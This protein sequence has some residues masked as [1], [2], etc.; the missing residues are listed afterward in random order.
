[1]ITNLQKKDAMKIIA[2][3]LIISVAIT[4]LPIVSNA[5]DPD[6]MDVTDKVTFDSFDFYKANSNGT[7][8]E[9]IINRGVTVDTVPQIKQNDYV[10]L[11][12]YWSISETGMESV[13]PGSFFTVNLPVDIKFEAISGSVDVKTSDGTTVIGKMTLSGS[14]GSQKLI[15]TLNET[16]A[17]SM[18]LKNGW[19]MIFGNV[20]KVDNNTSDASIFGVEIPIYVEPSSGGG[21]NSGSGTNM[22]PGDWYNWGWEG[23]GGTDFY[24]SAYGPEKYTGLT[25]FYLTVNTLMYKH[26]FENDGSYE[27][28]ENVIIEDKLQDGVTYSGNLYISTALY[29]VRGVNTT[30]AALDPVSPTAMSNTEINGTNM[31]LVNNLTKCTPDDE[32]IGYEEFK[33]FIKD[34]GPLTYG[35]WQNKAIVINLGDLEGQ[36]PFNDLTWSQLKVKVDSGS[37]IVTRYVYERDASGAA[38]IDP[39]TG[40]PKEPNTVTFQALTT[41]V[42]TETLKA[43]ASFFGVDKNDMTN[44][45]YDANTGS[46]VGMT[47]SFDTFI[48]GT[49]RLVTNTAFMQYSGGASKSGST[50][51]NFVQM[52]GGADFDP[53]AP[54][55][56]RLIK[57]D[58][59]TNAALEGVQFKLQKFNKTTEKYEDIPEGS[60]GSGIKETDKDGSILFKNLDWGKYKVVEVKALTGYTSKITFKDGD[61]TFELINPKEVIEIIAF[62]YKEEVLGDEEFPADNNDGSNV[63]GQESEP[64]QK[65]L[66]EEANTGDIINLSFILIVLLLALV[67]LIGMATALKGRKG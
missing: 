2:F 10:G 47:I 36:M 37:R 26:K 16:A 42:K 27:K 46:A 29:Y 11:K 52:S 61:G 18:S 20:N 58:S 12:Y 64:E 38:I 13:T 14:A 9:P 15:V 41:K 35:I 56:V 60:P 25:K 7:V 40:K 65:V 19:L 43:Y 31:N 49:D 21:G 23:N 4:M 22:N 6:P 24:K 5:D 57:L 33:Q 39:A 1:M 53:G 30:N 32:T 34:S 66:G 62:N 50:E 48:S 45:V 55:D 54:G 28:R 44:P 63:L 17:K 51:V 67:L 3:L 8:K 59:A